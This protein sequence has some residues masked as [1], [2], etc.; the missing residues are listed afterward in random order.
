MNEKTIE[1]YETKVAVVEDWIEKSIQTLKPG[2]KI[3]EIGSAYGRDAKIIEEKGFYVEKT[4]ATLDFVSILQEDDPS[5]RVLNI[6]TDEIDDTYDLILAN[7]VLLHFDDN[8][9]KSTVK[10]IHAAL[11]SNGTFSFTLKQGEGVA[12]QNNKDAALRFSNYWSEKDIVQLLTM[13]GF[14]DIDAWTDS[15]D[16]PHTTWI[17][18]IAKKSL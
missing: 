4:D 16:D 18:I 2:A 11:N 7:A 1:S 12:W 14:E 5:A 13:A 15:S 17:M 3:L 9:T 8:E 6:I 10:K